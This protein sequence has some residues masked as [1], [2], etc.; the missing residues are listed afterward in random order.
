ME[1]NLIETAELENPI[2]QTA[3][4][5]NRR[6]NIRDMQLSAD[7]FSVRLEM[8]TNELDLCGTRD[9]VSDA[10][11]M[12]EEQRCAADEAHDPTIEHS[13]LCVCRYR[14]V[15]RIVTIC[16]RMKLKPSRRTHRLC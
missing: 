7:L 15:L 10:V 2:G 1:P 16:E 8:K 6:K 14:S 4:C 13:S 3:Q 11:A 9:N 5:L 12:F